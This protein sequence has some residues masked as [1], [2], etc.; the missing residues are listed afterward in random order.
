MGNIEYLLLFFIKLLEVMR[1]GRGNLRLCRESCR[2]LGTGEQNLYQPPPIRFFS[3]GDYRSFLPI[4]ENG[5]NLSLI[6]LF[7]RIF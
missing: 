5:F 3:P 2:V 1:V 4:G 7:V 6:Y